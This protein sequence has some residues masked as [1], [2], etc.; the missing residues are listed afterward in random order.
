[1]RA[2]THAPLKSSLRWLCKN[3]FYAHRLQRSLIMLMYTFL[4]LVR[5]Q[6]RPADATYLTS[7][8]QSMARTYDNLSLL[9]EWLAHFCFLLTL[10]TSRQTSKTLPFLKKYTYVKKKSYDP[11]FWNFISCNFEKAKISPMQYGLVK[12]S[13]VSKAKN[14]PPPWE[15]RS[16]KT[17]HHDTWQH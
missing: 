4:W 14:S 10:S 17:H 6:S 5:N 2:Y 11:I 12:Y 13:S 15:S 7:L 1:M 9:P 3:G 8:F 16:K